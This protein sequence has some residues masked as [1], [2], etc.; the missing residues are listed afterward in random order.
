MWVPFLRSIQRHD[1]LSSLRRGLRLLRQGRENFSYISLFLFSIQLLIIA[2]IF[3]ITDRDF[4]LR[5]N[6]DLSFSR[7]VLIG[8][9]GYIGEYIIVRTLRSASQYLLIIELIIQWNRDIEKLMLRYHSL[10]IR[11]KKKM[12][13]LPTSIDNR[14]LYS[15]S[16][17]SVLHYIQTHNDSTMVENCHQYMHCITHLYSHF[18][19]HCYYW[20]VLLLNW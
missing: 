8:I 10:I 20:N 3:L 13:L 6:N 9:I 4:N 19:L 1:L 15:I 11:I 17:Q 5:F 18:Y 12:I 2:S 7:N 16:F 14:C